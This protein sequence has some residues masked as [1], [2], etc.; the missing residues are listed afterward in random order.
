MAYQ[1]SPGLL[2]QFILAEL[3]VL[4]QEGEA[5]SRSM[6]EKPAP[7]LM[8]LYGVRGYEKPAASWDT[9]EGSLP[10]LKKYCLEFQKSN[11]EKGWEKILKQ[12][13]LLLLLALQ[14]LQKG[15]KEE[16]LN[17]IPPA[18]KK[19]GQ[20]IL[21]KTEEQKEDENVLFFLLRSSYQLEVY[22][23][24]GFVKGALKKM[25]PGSLKGAED[26]ILSQYEKRGFNELL[27]LI[28]SGFCRL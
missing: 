13:D 21:K 24:K 15:T 6:K 22:L 28:T 16:A 9:F 10:K 26:Y 8:R 27:P 18:I 25:F 17:K 1:K 2:F 5:L 4:F 23:G 11:E 14:G 19:L 7:S 3:L 12:L 20:L